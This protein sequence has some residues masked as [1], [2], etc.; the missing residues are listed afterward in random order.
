MIFDF[1]YDF[2]ENF[3]FVRAKHG[4]SLDIFMTEHR[5]K[6]KKLYCIKKQYKQ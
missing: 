1:V 6:I 4:K 2:V 3:L 5:F